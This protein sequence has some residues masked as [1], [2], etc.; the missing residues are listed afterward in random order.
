MNLH[1]RLILSVLAAGRYLSRDR[2]IS[3]F[4]YQNIFLLSISLFFWGA[5]LLHLSCIFVPCSAGL[6]FPDMIP[7]VLG[8]FILQYVL[9]RWVYGLRELVGDLDKLTADKISR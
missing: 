5:A 7:T 3:D 1:Y 9:V 4:A 2:P 6:L 8:V